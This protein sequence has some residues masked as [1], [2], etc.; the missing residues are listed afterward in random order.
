M[1][2]ERKKAQR[3]L[4]DMQLP[5]SNNELITMA[6][7]HPSYAQEKNT[8]ANNQRL[9]FLGDAVLNLVVAEYLYNHYARKAEGE[10]TKI[11]AKVVCEDALA[12]FAHNIDLG[13]YL[14]LGRGEEMSGGRKRKSILADAVEAVIGAIYLDQGLV[15]VQRF[16][17]KHLEELISE[18][19]S[20][21]Y[22]DY[23]SKLQE[24][25]QARDKENVSYAIIE[26]SG[27][28]HAKIFV[29]GVYYREQLLAAGEGKSKKEAEQKAAQKVLQD[30]SLLGE[31]GF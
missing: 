18:T 5:Y 6:L 2:N 25:V 8:V 11:R 1:Q 12:I 19:A 22:Y 4:E 15:T 26:E 17:M 24:L 21:D 20:G 29:A 16:I 3:F 13:Q 30:S 10:L 9:E 7:T 23:K 28:A 31:L 14:L 27:P